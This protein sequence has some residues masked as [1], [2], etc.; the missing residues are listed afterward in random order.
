MQL[1]KMPFGNKGPRLT[2]RKKKKN[3]H[4]D[5]RLSDCNNIAKKI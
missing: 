4:K 2:Y 1:C 5:N 3:Y